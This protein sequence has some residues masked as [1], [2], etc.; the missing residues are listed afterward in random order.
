MLSARILV[1]IAVNRS[2]IREAR[3]RSVCGRI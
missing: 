1:V 2:S 3:S